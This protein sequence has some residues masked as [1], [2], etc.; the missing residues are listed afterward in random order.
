[1]HTKQFLLS[2]GFLILFWIGGC[3]YRDF[4]TMTLSGAAQVTPTFSSISEKILLPKCVQCHD[5]RRRNFST[6]AGI[7]NDVEAYRPEESELDEVVQEGSM[8][9][10]IPVLSDDE[11]IA[12]YLWIQN[13]AKND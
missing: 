12:I 7:I 2:L 10:G 13:G 4:K 11:V 3:G 5:S 6:Y 8:P 1:M 9:I